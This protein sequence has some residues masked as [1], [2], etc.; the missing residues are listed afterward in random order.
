M[1]KLSEINPQSATPLYVQIIELVKNGILLESIKAGDQLPSVRGLA[2]D[3]QVNS[4]TIQKAYKLLE[5]EGVIQIR[6]GVGA[7]VSDDI[8]PVNKESKY[9]IIQDKLSPIIEQAKS[10]ELEIDRVINCV[11]EIWRTK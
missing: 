8:K 6:K 2:K 9:Q 7:F 3:L 5:A 11:D 4:L 10:M 1:F